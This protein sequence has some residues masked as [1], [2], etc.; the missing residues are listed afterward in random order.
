MNESRLLQ[1]KNYIS[2]VRWQYAKTYVTSPY[3]YTVLGWAPETKKKM[4]DFAKLIREK[5]VDEKFGNSTFRFLFIDDMKY[6]TMD[7]PVENTDL[8]NR[9]YIDNSKRKTITDFVQSGKFNFKKGMSLKDITKQIESGIAAFISPEGRLPENFPKAAD[10]E[11]N[12]FR[13]YISRFEWRVA[14]TFEKFSPHQYIL[15]F[16]CWKM[17][18]DGKC[19]GE[20]NACTDC[21]EKR[22]EFEKW[23]MFIRKYGE[24]CKMLKKVYTVFCL[25]GRQ[26]WT[27]GD[28]LETTWVLNRALIDEPRRVPKLMGD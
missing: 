1:A 24:R 21:H 9:T 23:V 14:K 26:Y 6:W 4:I 18:K 10:A 15:N 5:G 16:P 7:A 28:P 11:I 17:K 20:S 13:S 3:E 12:G 22:A 25:D 2:S 19:P 8:I 27:M